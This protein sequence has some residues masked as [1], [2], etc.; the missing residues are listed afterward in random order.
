[1]KTIVSKVNGNPFPA[2]K[3]E[4]VTKMKTEKAPINTVKNFAAGTKE[5]PANT[6]KVKTVSVNGQYVGK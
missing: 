3:K 1:M 5:K 6:V 4:G 2:G